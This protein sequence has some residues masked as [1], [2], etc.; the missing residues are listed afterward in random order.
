[1]GGGR[2]VEHVCTIHA[3]MFNDGLN[4]DTLAV[5]LLNAVL[6]VRDLNDSPGCV[7]PLRLNAWCWGVFR[8]VERRRVHVCVTRLGFIQPLQSV[9]VS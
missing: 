8:V 4:A 2:A 9:L 1:M 3:G 5:D 7:S 6:S